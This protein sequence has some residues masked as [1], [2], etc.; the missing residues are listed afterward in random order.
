MAWQSWLA[1]AQPWLFISPMPKPLVFAL[2]VV[3]GLLLSNGGSLFVFSAVMMLASAADTKSW[4]SVTGTVVSSTVV[5]QKGGLGVTYA[6]EIQYAYQVERKDYH[7]TRIWM[8]DFDADAWAR[9]IAGQGDEARARGIAAEF[10]AGASVPVYYLASDPKSSVLKPGAS[11]FI[12]FLG[13]LGLVG[14]AVSLV[15]TP[16]WGLVSLGLVFWAALT[17]VL[18]FFS[19]VY[20][21]IHARGWF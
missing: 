5:Q 18:A 8:V 14:I 21:A 6:P 3:A 12:Y 19:F 15:V 7:G 17:I 4:P 13:G 1:N 20:P 9:E 2:R 11:A 16:N 10:P